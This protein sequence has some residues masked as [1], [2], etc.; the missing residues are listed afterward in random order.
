MRLV[1]KE[2]LEDSNLKV[3][4][5]SNPIECL[6][7]L[8]SKKCDLLITDLKMPEKNGIDLVGLIHSRGVNG[9]GL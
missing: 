8:R 5:F 9:V 7:R 1:G 6:A 4:C 2:T 3:S